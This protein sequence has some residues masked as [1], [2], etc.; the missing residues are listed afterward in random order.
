M[1]VTETFV[2][3]GI[4]VLGRTT[5]RGPKNRDSALKTAKNWGFSLFTNPR[6]IFLGQT[7]RF[8]SCGNQDLSNATD[9]VLLAGL[10]AEIV[11]FVVVSY[12]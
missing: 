2:P 5:G 1:M 7:I 9:R 11:V 4:S 8:C 12:R 10:R 3:S 6:T